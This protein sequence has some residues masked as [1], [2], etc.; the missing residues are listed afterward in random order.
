MLPPD[1]NRIVIRVITHTSTRGVYKKSRKRTGFEDSKLSMNEIKLKLSM[2][3]FLNFEIQGSTVLQ[4]P[5]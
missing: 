2:V 4:Y 1:E 5:V 3:S